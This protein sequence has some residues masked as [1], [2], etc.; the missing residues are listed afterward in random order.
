MT[1]WQQAKLRERRW[2]AWA[3]G[4]GRSR[5]FERRSRKKSTRAI[6][7]RRIGSPSCNSIKFLSAHGNWTKWMV[8]APCTVTCGGGILTYGRFCSRPRPRFGGA[9]C[10]GEEEKQE[11][12]NTNAC[13]TINGGWSAWTDATMCTQTCGVDFK[14]VARTCTDPAPE[15]G[16][17]N[18]TGVSIETRNCPS[19]PDC[20]HLSE[21]KIFCIK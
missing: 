19:L 8:L 12:C 16:G 15:H 3:L 6:F 4:R 20:P 1:L 2:R 10:Q 7:E 14:D 18:C 17:L 21:K 5:N 9:D 11:V 13:P